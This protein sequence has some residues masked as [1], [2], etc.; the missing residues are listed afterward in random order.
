M[1]EFDGQKIRGREAF[2][3]WIREDYNRFEKLRNKFY[4]YF[5]TEEID[6]AEIYE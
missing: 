4:E 3:N 6:N 2:I 1:Y 5:Q